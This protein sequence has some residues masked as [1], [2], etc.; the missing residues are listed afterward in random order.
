LPRKREIHPGFF[1]NEDIA[2]LEP[3]A[4]LLLIGMWNLADR[5]GRLEDRPKKLRAELLPYD[6]CDGETL[7]AA[8]AGKGF[9][10]RY[11]VDGHKY[12]QVNNWHKYQDVHPK[13]TASII[14]PMSGNDLEPTEDEPKVTIR[15]TQGEPKVNPGTTQDESFNP[16]PSYPSIPSSTSNTS[17]TP[18]VPSTGDRGAKTD[19]QGVLDEYNATC[20]KMP[21]A[22][23]LNKTRRGL[24]NGRIKEYGRGAITEVFR[25]ASQSP[26]HNGSNDRGWK[27]DFT[28][29]MGP[30]NFV[31]MLERARSG[32]ISVKKKATGPARFKEFLEGLENDNTG[33]NGD[34]D[35]DCEHI[36]ETG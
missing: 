20:V 22:E 3:L 21:K 12:I 13:E 16:I 5:E 35:I 1:K 34:I 2:E 24:I 28:W 26:H 18:I 36:S 23:A 17:L 4:R 30:D 9:I 8:I 27:A 25:Y 14:P 11:E 29:L 7:I 6:S 31:K 32:T 33:N 10:I 19:Y 15:N